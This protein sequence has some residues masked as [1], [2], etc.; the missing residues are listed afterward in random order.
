MGF[1]VRL[2]GEGIIVEDLSGLGFQKLKAGV[3][4]RTSPCLALWLS[5]SSATLPFLHRI[6][7]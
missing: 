3:T 7:G 2:L 6:K 1:H 4:E 5:V